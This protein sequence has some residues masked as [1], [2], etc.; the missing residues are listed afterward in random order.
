MLE[1]GTKS[2]KRQVVSTVDLDLLLRM[3]EPIP[4][5]TSYPTAPEWGELS[6]DRY[7]QK[8]S[9][10][11]VENDALSVYIH[12]P[13]CSSMCL[14]CG[15]S[16]VLNRRADKEERY[17]R[18][19]LQ[20]LELFASRVKG[21]FRITQLHFGGG[22]PSKLTEEQLTR[23]M[24]KLRSLFDLDTEGEFSI[25]I[26][27]RTVYADQGAKLRHLRYLGLNRVSFGVQDTDAQVQE[28]VK[29]RQSYEM[30]KATFQWAKELEFSGINIDLIYGLPYQT[31]RSF[32]KTVEEIA[33][34]EPDRIALYSYAKVPWLKPHQKAIKDSTLPETDEKFQIYQ[35]ARK[36]LV[37]KGYLALGMD[38]FARE[39]DEIAQAYLENKLQRNFQGYS[40]RLAENMIGFGVTSIGYV[41]DCYVQNVKELDDYYASIDRKKLPASRGLV[42]SQ[43]DIIRKWVIHRLMC[44]FSLFKK[45]FSD[46]FQ[47]DF[48]EYFEKELSNL[49]CFEKEKFLQHDAD[50]IQITPLGELFIRNIVC[51]FDAYYGKAKE[52][53]FSKGV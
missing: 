2:K 17:V 6:V 31:K 10:L 52:K 50:H 47:I 7:E 43:D 45:D 13:F 28:A 9:E 32:K 5:Y 34:L 39:N 48:D 26:D 14:Y 30:T 35:N 4:R 22:T 19:L 3:N 18:Y 12:I 27:P 42:L 41:K 24:A 21:R 38:H 40:L 16:V 44:N 51:I 53:R 20:E 11:S 46:R 29:R 25:E 33:D 36:E 23:I 49:A 15:C 8:L 37:D 1:V